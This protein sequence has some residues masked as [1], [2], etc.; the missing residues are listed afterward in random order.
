MNGS[1]DRRGDI[2][3]K[4]Q[5]DIS[6]FAGV[7]ARGN[8]PGGFDNTLR[9]AVTAFLQHPTVAVRVREVGEAR[10]VPACWVGSGC[11]TCVAG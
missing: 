6:A 7:S 4:G 10:V 9:I 5:P 1:V 8:R 11:E 3:A 2:A